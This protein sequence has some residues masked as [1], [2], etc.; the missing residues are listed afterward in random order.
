[1]AGRRE[2]QRVRDLL[3]EIERKFPPPP[4]ELTLAPE[5][6]LLEAGEELWRIYFQGGRHPT[7]WSFFRSFGPT[8]SRFDHHLAESPE[9][10]ILYAAPEV[11][12]CLAEVF[13]EPRI[14]DREARAPWLVGFRLARPLALLDLTGTWP[15]RV[16]ASMAIGSGPRPRAQRWSRA[17]YASYPEI[18]GVYY[19]S[20][21]HANRPAVALYE[22]AEDA[23]P[24]AP[25]FHRPLRDPALLEALKKAAIQLGYELV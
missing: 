1:M 20:S 17:I 2:E 11:V 12:T 15:T 25:T 22:R 13:Q 4:S 10:R 24:G 23:L 6:R 5:I 8:T 7:G 3:A 21:M 9:R 14:I 18:D 16:G 19:S